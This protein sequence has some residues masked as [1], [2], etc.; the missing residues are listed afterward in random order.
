MIGRSVG[1]TEGGLFSDEEY[2]IYEAKNEKILND[3]QLGV[4]YVIRMIDTPRLK[5]ELGPGISGGLVHVNTRTKTNFNNDEYNDE[6]FNDIGGYS[7]GVSLET[8]V[9]INDRFFITAGVEYRNY[10]MAPLEH[11]S[12][13]SQQIDQ[14]GVNFYIGV[15]VRF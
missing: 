9:T 10:V 5:L 2:S 7:Y 4:R 11:D 12:G 1:R 13:L 6:H 15:G 3:I 8:K 14:E